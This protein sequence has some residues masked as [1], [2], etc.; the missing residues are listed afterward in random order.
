MSEQ[1]SPRPEWFDE[2]V[3]VGVVV[4]DLDRSIEGLS[5]IFG[6]RSFGTLDWPPEGRKMEK[7]YHGEPGNFTAKMA[8]TRLGPVELELIQPLEGDSIWADFLREHGEGIHHIRFNVLELEPLFE[9][10][11]SQ[12]I[13][14]SQWG[15]GIRPGTAWANFGSEDAVG[16]VIEVMKALPGTD[17]L[18]PV[19]ADD[20]A[21]S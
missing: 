3:Q 18:T 7:Y 9:Y 17:G 5:R 21:E 14:V 1:P 2:I 6:I 19:A 12:G 4:R 15:A 10:M 20:V 16:F 8:F 11:S 13:E